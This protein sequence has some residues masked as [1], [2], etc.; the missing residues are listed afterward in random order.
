MIT[1]KQLRELRNNRGLSI[2]NAWNALGEAAD[3]IEELLKLRIGDG[4]AYRD[5]TIESFQAARKNRE[6]RD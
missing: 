6:Q 3:T 5:D 4:N 1:P 2:G